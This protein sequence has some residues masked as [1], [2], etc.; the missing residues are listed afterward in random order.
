MHLVNKSIT[1]DERTLTLSIVILEGVVGS[2]QG[3]LRILSSI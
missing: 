1:R 2:W 3:I